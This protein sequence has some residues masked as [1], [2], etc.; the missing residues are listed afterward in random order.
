[1]KRQQPDRNNAEAAACQK[2]R[3][4]EEDPDVKGS[5]CCC[6]SEEAAALLQPHMKDLD[7]IQAELQKLEEECAK[8]QM[9]VQKEFDEKKKPV[10]VKRQEIIDKIPGFWCRC[11]RNHPQLAY[12]VEEDI[13]ILEHLKRID[14]DDNID[15]HGSYKIKFTFDEAA[16]AFME[17]LVLEKHVQ[18]HNDPCS[19]EV[20]SVTEI[21]WKEG[22]SPVAAAEAKRAGDA[23]DDVDVVSFFEWFTKEPSEEA[24]RLEV[25]EIIRREIWHAPVPY[26]LDEVADIDEDDDEDLSDEDEDEEDGSD[27]AN[28]EGGDEDDEGDE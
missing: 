12:L 24:S 8:Q 9:V 10:L 5:G 18:F 14:L 6:S 22:K 21:T 26:F 7:G 4:L 25:G 1:M 27:N 15:E 28:E 11:L 19:E 2:Q 16:K 23:D 17:P 13:P 3:R 20:V